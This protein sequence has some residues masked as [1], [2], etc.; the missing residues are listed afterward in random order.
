M[1]VDLIKLWE[2]APWL[3]LIVICVIATIFIT[4]LFDRTKRHDVAIAETRSDIKGVSSKLDNLIGSVSGMQIALDYLS[5]SVSSMQT[6]SASRIKSPMQLTEL[7]DEIL[8]KSHL[9]AEIDAIKDFLF[10]EIES[11]HPE[12][13]ADVDSE[14]FSILFGMFSNKMFAETRMFIYENPVYGGEQLN[15]L[16]VSRLGAIYLRNLYINESKLAVEWRQT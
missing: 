11:R 1:S 2:V 14:C 5:A 6:G 9:K 3:C 4:R 16:M 13:D 15:G 8:E 12:N 7:G 10:D